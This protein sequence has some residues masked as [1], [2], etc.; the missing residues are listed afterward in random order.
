MA[1]RS[2]SLANSTASQSH[3]KHPKTLSVVDAISLII[4]LVIGTGIF[5]TPAFVAT[6]AGSTPSALLLWLMGGGISFVGALCYAEL[7]TTYPHPGGN[8]YY[9]QRAFGRGVSFLFAWARLSIIQT[10]SLAMLAFVFGNY[11]SQIWSFGTYS[12]SIYAAF[13]IAFTTGINLLGIRQ[14]KWAQNSLTTAKLTILVLILIAGLV[15]TLPSQQPSNLSFESIPKSN[16]GLAM[17]FVL[18]TYGGW[19]EAAYLSA[20]LKSVEKN[21]TRT[22]FWSIGIVTVT[23]ILVNAAF[24]YGLGFVDTS[25]STTLAADLLRQFLGQ[26]GAAAISLPIAVSALGAIH[27]TTF[28]GARTNYALGRDFPRFGFLGYWHHQTQTPT[29]ALWIQGAIALGLVVGGSFARSGF[30]VMVEYTAPVFWFFFL[31]TGISLLILRQ[32]E[33][34]IERPFHVPFYP[35]IPLVFCGIC[36]Y[37]LQSSLAHTGWGALFGVGVLLLGLPL[38]LFTRRHSN[39]I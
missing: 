3:Y 13:A 12:P 36:L 24:L 19:N 15:L 9:L 21:M 10:G 38:L 7:T 17:V 30:E 20:E 6:N 27:A 28:T 22:L 11:A 34:E 32:R 1:T 18:L 26:P 8:Y 39:S 35:A 33:P 37:M 5:E 14:G 4:G 2:F 25:T 23:Y 31:L 29:H 16:F